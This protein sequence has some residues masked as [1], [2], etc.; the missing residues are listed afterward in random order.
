MK[1]VSI[2]I[3]LVIFLFFVP[4]NLLSEETKGILITGT[5]EEAIKAAGSVNLI[6]EKDLEK[7]LTGVDDIHR[8]LRQIPGVNIQEEDGYGL[9]PNIGFRGVPNERSSKITLMEDGILIAPAPYT[10]PSAYYFPPVGRMSGIEVSKGPGMIKYGPY[11]TGG[12]LNLLST[13][14]PDKKSA[15]IKFGVG[16][17]NTRKIYA[18]GGGKQDNLS[19]MIETYQLTTDGFKKI[20]GGGNSDVNLE[21][22]QA[23]LK[24]NSNPENNIY[25]ELEY[26]IGFYDQLSNE[27]YLGLTE[28]DFNKSPYRRYAGSQLDHINADHLQHHLTHRVEI[29][30]ET[31]VLTQVYF[32]QTQRNWSKLDA[33]NGIGISQILDSPSMFAQE[34]AWI[35][36]ESSNE[37][38]FKI[39]DNQRD[40]ESYGV[41]SVFSTKFNSSDVSHDVDF[42]MRF[43]TDQEDRFQHD[44]SY[45]MQNNRLVLSSIGAP[46]SQTNRVSSAE[47]WSFYL[48]DEVKYGDLTFLPGARFERINYTREDY[49]KNDSARTGVELARNDTNVSAF[50]PG[51][52]VSY[53][54]NPET[55]LF[56]GV[57]KGFSPQ[58][59]AS[60]SDV[61]KEES[62][63]YELGASYLEEEFF[64]KVVMFFNDY[65]NLL[66]A[67]TLS[68]GGQGTGDLFN[69]GAVTV[70]GAEFNLGYNYLCSNTGIK[71]PVN[72]AYTYTNSEFDSTFES[73]FFG[74]VTKGDQVPYIPENQFSLNIGA[75]K[76]DFG[77]YFEGVYSDSMFSVA[78]NNLSSAKTDS[79]FVLD[80]LTNWQFQPNLKA[81]ANVENL[82][83]SEYVVSRRPAGARPGL[84]RTV[85]VGAEYVF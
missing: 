2:I 20:D 41:Q 69:A 72:F 66:G 67:D 34:L 31:Q 25:H 9:R 10:A 68:S 50:I 35:K 23:K 60:N 6:D 62:I 38:V 59:A 19:A 32:N 46:G 42:G 61:K 79:F 76:G 26:K 12:A 33:V 28:E 53:E 16:N 3:S 44:S 43:H 11:T 80:F 78:G 21:D 74:S 58:G 81:Y 36:G 84:P 83:D 47:A 18:S 70:Y 85:I 77:A 56:V 52:S 65:N 22:Y 27:T 75:E 1:K 64:S 8:V 57:H 40:Y 73:E 48:Q 63:N 39:R 24:L 49:G 82:L 14:V 15:K 55:N 7:E 54:L 4:I 71:F 13:P 45:S 37:A 29:N 5:K 30:E 51:V 17:N